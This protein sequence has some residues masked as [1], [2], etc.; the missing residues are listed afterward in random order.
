M[1]IRLVAPWISIFAL[2]GLAGFGI[3]HALVNAPTPAV[4]QT[5]A[6]IDHVQHSAA[7]VDVAPFEQSPRR[8]VTIAGRDAITG[9]HQQVQCTV[10]AA[11]VASDALMVDLEDFPDAVQGL[12]E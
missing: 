5:Q 8:A 4:S 9:E 2:S 6:T 1:F 11:R 3:D 7:P 12:C 10:D